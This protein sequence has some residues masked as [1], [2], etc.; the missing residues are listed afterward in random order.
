MKKVFFRALMMFS[1]GVFLLGC[2]PSGPEYF[3]DRDVVLSAFDE[4]YVFT[5]KQTYA[6]PDQIVTDVKIDNNGDTI[7]TYMSQIYASQLLQAIESN[8]S[9]YGWQRVDISETPDL[10]L[11]PAAISS[12]TYYASYWYDYWYGGW[13]GGW[14]WYY[15]PYY[16]V[17]SYTTGS[18][19]MVLSDPNLDTP[20]NKSPIAWISAVNGVLGSNDISRALDGINQAFEQSAYLQIN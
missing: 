19:I 20:I 18:F 1:S 16:N 2:Y 7:R 11:A 3:D 4:D 10:I 14:G 15:P 12:T 6:M 5:E 9:S 8:M 17:S 13:Y